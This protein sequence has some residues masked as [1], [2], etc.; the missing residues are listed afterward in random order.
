MAVTLSQQDYW[1]LVHESQYPGFDKAETF[2]IVAQYPERLGQGYY[3]FIELRDGLDLLIS[4]HQLYNDVT[5]ILPERPHPIECMFYI[6]GQG[7]QPHGISAGQHALYGSGTAPVEISRDSADKPILEVNVHIDSSLLKTYLGEAFDL[8]S[9]GLEH[10]IRPA[11]QLYYQRFDNTTAAM[12]TALHQLLHCPFKGITQKLYFESK[13][14][15]LMALLIEQELALQDNARQSVSIRADDIERIHHAKDILLKRLDNPPSLLE[16]SRQ[17]GLNDC[18][19]KRGFRQVFGETAFGYLHKCRMEKA[20]QLLVEGE[21]NVS[22]A[23]R[24]VGFVNRSYFAAAFRKK[25]GVSPSKYLRQK[26]YS[27]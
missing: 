19:L 2:E 8:T 16:L 4:H 20:R 21:M 13:V 14:W 5:V 12:Q 22:E 15:E 18:A 9:A 10:L 1:D 24:Q 23:A 11:E 3:R 6:M 27:G 7:N 26:N 17:V 25:F